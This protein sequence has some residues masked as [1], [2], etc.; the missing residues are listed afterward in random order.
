MATESQ[1]KPHL[2]VRAPNGD[3]REFPLEGIIVI[4]RDESS[5]IR[6]E[7]KKVSRRHAAFKVIDGEPYVEDL[8]SSNGVK[9][10][11]TRIEKRVLLDDRSEVQV[12]GYQITIHLPEPPSYPSSRFDDPSG[13]SVGTG[14]MFRSVQGQGRGAVLQESMPDIGLRSGSSSMMGIRGADP[15]L[16]G[17]TPPV[18]GRRFRLRTGE[19]IIGRLEECDVNILHASVSRQHARITVE[20]DRVRIQD[21]G[22]ANGIFVEGRRASRAVL[23]SSDRLR[24]GDVIFRVEIPGLRGEAIE[25][26]GDRIEKPSETSYGGRVL[27]LFLMLGFLV[28]GLAL[29]YLGVRA[30]DRVQQLWAQIQSDVLQVAGLDEA[31]TPPREA[32]SGV[33]PLEPASKPLKPTSSPR[34]SKMAHAPPHRVETPSS[35][36]SSKPRIKADPASVSL[37]SVAERVEPRPEPEDLHFVS[38]LAPVTTASSPWSRT[39]GEGL[40]QSLPNVDPNEDLL[41]LVSANVA[42]AQRALATGQRVEARKKAKRVL[43]L[44]PIHA[45][46]RAMLV[47]LAEWDA[48]DQ[49]IARADKFIEEGAVAD[50]YAILSKVPEGLPQA[51]QARARGERIREQAMKDAMTRAELEAQEPR[52]WRSA[53]ARYKLVLSLDAENEGALA[54]LRALERRM[55]EKKMAFNAWQRAADP[56]SL[57]KAK[58]AL[59]KMYPS[60]TSIVMQYLHGKLPIAQR[61]VEARLKRVRPKR[62]GRPDVEVQRLRKF[63]M[64]MLEI[65]KRFERTRTEVANDPS[66]AWAMLIEIERIEQSF[67]PKGFRSYLV[68]E[69]R[70]DLSDAFAKDGEAQF[71]AHRY[72]AAFQRWEAGHKLDS[73]NTRIL[74]G[75]TRLEKVAK[76]E[77]EEGRIAEKRGSSNEAC[78]R[79]RL[80]TR[81]TRSSADIHT[82]ARRRAALACP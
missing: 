24:V 14:P 58:N 9:V 61:Q 68:E 80:V 5:D 55:R 26:L 4:G 20:S 81:M 23:A 73:K 41:D 77:A 65:Q 71:D 32:S 69:L 29:A 1:K 33:P 46:A 16:I 3:V 28:G 7:D 63:K 39:N 17:V 44:D 79:F 8:G 27:A 15:M 75:L 11:G 50:A 78:R 18:E 19:N 2:V 66:Q 37:P 49:A 56:E 74:K 34:L 62:R 10:D 60:G 30:P 53:H 72:E 57:V 40:P 12:G 52:S 22:S 70:A 13:A 64:G 48:M 21:L 45:D 76:S 36:P 31:E 38:V 67:L 82:E 43:E 59:R 54:G 51:A 42:A 47:K 35:R 25:S 6:V